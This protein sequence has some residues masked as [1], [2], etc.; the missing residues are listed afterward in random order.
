LKPTSRKDRA[1]GRV[2][3]KSAASLHTKVFILDR[4]TIFI[5]SLNLD[6]R[7]IDINTEMGIVFH[8]PEMAGKMARELDKDGLEH[9]YELQLV[10]SPAESK[11]EYTTY[12]WDIEWLERVDGE[13]IRHT[14][15]PG[16]GILESIKLF[17]SSFAP[18]SLI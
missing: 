15:E 6:P 18:E 7:S 16:V 11:G 5:G 14:S 10:R 2:A 3:F 9:V 12:T 1:A 4:E 13:T 17:F 8:S